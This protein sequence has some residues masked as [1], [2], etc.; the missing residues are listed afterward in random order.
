M[1]KAIIF[2]IVLLAAFGGILINSK[3]LI[4]FL[5]LGRWTDRFDKPGERLRRV[6][7]VAIGQSK[8]FRDPIA[9][10]VHAFIFWGFLVLIFAVI[11]AIG[12]GLTAGHFSLSFLGPVYTV[13]TVSQDIFMALV[14]TS[15]V[16]SFWRRFVTK[17][18]R[19]QGDRHERIDAS[20]ILLL[21]LV[22]VCS[23]TIA[24]AARMALGNSYAWEVRPLAALLM[25]MFLVQ[26]G[27][28][29]SASAMTPFIYESAWWIHIV[30]VL[31]FMNY[32]P[33]SK[34]LH[35]LTSLPNV[36]FADLKRK[37]SLAPINFE[38][39]TITQ[40]GA[41]D[42]QHL[43]WK[44]LLDGDT[45]TH[46]GRCTS[47][48]PANS[49][50]KI[51][52]PRMIIIATHKRM[53]DKAPYLT[54][55][56][57][58][59]FD[60]W[61]GQAMKSHVATSGEALNDEIVTPEN[62]TL[63]HAQGMLLYQK[64]TLTREEVDA[65][66]F[67]GDYIPDEMLWQCTTCQACMTEC[68]VTI[69]HVDEI[70]DLRRNLVMMESSFPPEL[71]SAFGNMENNFSPWAF[72]PSERGEWAE[73][74]GVKTM[75]DGGMDKPPVLFWVGCAG[76][77]DQR[78]KRISRAFAELMQIAG[79]DFRILG[80]EEKCTGDPARRMG[81]EYLAQSL[82]RENVET[83]NRY[84]VQ[85]VVTACP[86][87]FNAIKNEW[88]QFGGNFEVV[89]HTELI[90]DLLDQGRIKPKNESQQKA[91]YHDSCYL[92][93]SNDIYEAPRTSLASVP[94][95][96]IIEMDRSR[97]RGFCCGAGGGQMW[98]EEKQGKRI[99]IERT[100]EALAT[101]AKVVASACPYCMT[102]LTD[103]VKAKGEQE[104]VQVKD[105]AEIVL[106]SVR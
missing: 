23:L 19:L 100:E 47:V 93:R 15:V 76:S 94:G 11:E 17:V 6:L 45:C 9:G 18:K 35:V 50:G 38:D 81:N 95:L 42:I 62:Q 22:I 63:S 16:V 73:G 98:M 41:A 29:L 70:I 55:Q 64:P 33:Y 37:N 25:P 67:V 74:L 87:C 105:I 36:F 57:A 68:P 5:R 46:C 12:E 7:T 106:E 21:I 83:L 82:I 61:S 43:T 96:D 4:D 49:T 75:A 28:H 84:Q 91:T 69:E 79:V 8:I 80:N 88:Q 26:S 44:Q 39:E 24:N 30:F 85:K 59:G 54:A 58:Y 78:A 104:T 40:Y 51:L 31:G 92:G 60:T 52:D 53:L 34:H 101:G 77:Y 27:S 14:V 71:Q 86:H 72:S 32:L 1:I 20:V 65:K 99:N 103:G 10:P 102:M 2:A 13:I 66:K 90:Q 3:R 48:C 56:S 89:H 97:S